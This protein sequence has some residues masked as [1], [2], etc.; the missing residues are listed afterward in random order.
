MK[1]ITDFIVQRR[2]IILAIFVL[3]AGASL[4]VMQKVQINHDMTEYLPEDS[5][6]KMGLDVMEA[7][8]PKED[9]SSLTIMLEGLGE[10]EKKDTLEYLSEI[11][12]IKVVNYDESTKYNRD[13][14]VRYV[15]TVEGA[16][17]SETARGVYETLE[18]K[19]KHDEVTFGGEVAEQNKEVLPIWIIALAI[20]CALVILIIM[21]ES[22]VE[23]FLF[24]FTILIAVLLN[25]GT[26][27]IFPS[28]SNIT[29]SI[30]AIL[31]LALSMDYSIMLMN[32]YSQ[33]KL[34]SPNRVEAMKRALLYAFKSISSSSITTVVGLLALV[35][36][37]FTIGRD[38][39]F[40]LA[41][42]VLFS[43]LAIFTCLPGLILLFDRAIEK[44]RKK[45]PSAKLDFMGRIAYKG[46]YVAVGFFVL[47]FGTSYL[48][49]GNLG[50]LYTDSSE[51]RISQVF[52]ND[53]QMAVIYNN[54]NEE[55]I[56]EYCRGLK[57]E[58]KVAEVLC[59]GNT[60]GQKFTADELPNKMQ[61][62]GVETDLPDYMIRIIYYHY[63]NHG[64]TGRMSL[65]EFVRF[66]EDD[67]YLDENFA[68]YV[69]PAMRG[70]IADLKNFASSEAVLR[71]RSAD[72]LANVLGLNYE[73]IDDLLV[74]SNS[75]NI[76]TRL[77]VGELVRFLNEY[78]LLSPRYA[79]SIDDGTKARLA[80]IVPFVN[81]NWVQTKL[82]EAEIAQTFGIETEKVKVLYDYCGYLKILQEVE[83]HPELSSQLPGLLA[84]PQEIKMTPV[85]FVDFVIT[86]YEDPILAGN[87]SSET[88]SKLSFAQKMMQETLEGRTYTTK[89]VANLFGIDEQT[90]KLMYSLYEMKWQGKNVS[91]SLREFVSFLLDD[92]MMRPAY[93]VNFD[94]TQRAKLSTL[95]L[96]MNQTL[97][98]VAYTPA[99]LV[100]TLSTLTNNL[101]QDLIEL[102]YI[103]HG[104]KY[105]YVSNWEMTIEELVKYVDAAILTDARFDQFISSEMRVDIQDAREKVADAK[106]MLVGE[107]FSRIVLNT[108]FDAESEE[109][110][111]FLQSLHDG[112]AD[113]GG[114]FYVIGD[115]A[116][117][118]EMSKT[119]GAE[120]DTIT[121]ITMIF[122]FVVVALTFGSLLIPIIL[123]LLIQCAVYMTMGIL[124]MSGTDTYFIA[125]LIVQSILMGATIDYAILYTS[126]YIELRATKRVKA[127]VSEA[128]NKSIHAI[129]TSSSILILV[130]LIVGNCTTGITSMIL[131][132]IAKGTICATVLILV[133]LPAMLVAF[134]KLIMRNKTHI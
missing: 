43:L 132:T 23:P 78:V 81:Q 67:I 58:G 65:N 62:L 1:K 24:L 83:K 108:E 59:Y 125:L 30:T 91:M 103:Y 64:G 31:Q 105:E 128:Y 88:I 107:N 68:S 96:V 77:T 28:V 27:L 16:A 89:E 72:E 12:D 9:E 35:F 41:K 20:F 11:E 42:G 29:D 49:R 8:F 76:N 56:A 46:R 3:L 53:N 98:G 44:T 134:D 127:A 10:N 115:S 79:S 116:M 21:S 104:S 18:E 118:Y 99:E 124:S 60:I 34:N 86:H 6:V 4:F 113:Q 5:E 36:M 84:Q 129:A 7:E 48:L 133:L 109:T 45:S 73:Q 22:Y 123:V 74:Y 85:E 19:Y 17:D 131:L 92:V 71:K 47:V 57:A 102:L 66:I 94:M 51:D 70:E 80:Q 25:K 110:F 40:V 69:E 2:N 122:I 82:S 55:R 95:D 14:Y 93:A 26:N 130:T 119:F 87:V 63:Y 120:L 39:G 90:V 50:I 121:I 111:S 52:G 38:M 97:S 114:E 15:L 106:A 33:E 101:D 112:M 126:Y 32:R 75:K 117:A 100:E 37:S 13:G 61:E 54:D